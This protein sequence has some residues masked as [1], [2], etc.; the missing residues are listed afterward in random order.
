MPDSADSPL[1]VPPRPDS[2]KFWL[3]SVIYLFAFFGILWLSYQNA[4]DGKLWMQLF[5]ALG[6]PVIALI[7]AIMP[8]TERYG[9]GMLLAWPIGWVLG[10]A[11]LIVNYKMLHNGM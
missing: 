11:Y 7:F 3:G 4:G 9:R 2:G 1:S 8:K 6:L 5:A 10:F